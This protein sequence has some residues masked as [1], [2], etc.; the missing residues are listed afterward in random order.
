MIND[1]VYFEIL[2]EAEHNYICA[3]E[4]ETDSYSHSIFIARAEALIEIAVVLKFGYIDFSVFDD[5]FSSI[6]DAYHNGMTA[7]IT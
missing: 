1:K 7:Y 6:Q 3:K 5:I 4:M 2:S